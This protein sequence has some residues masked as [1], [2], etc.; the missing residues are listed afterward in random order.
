M[1]QV[2]IFVR[3]V[4]HLVAYCTLV[5][6]FDINLHGIHRTGICLKI[7]DNILHINPQENCHEL[8]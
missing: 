4:F 6:E 2:H 3:N 1:L 7:T 8:Q 5:H